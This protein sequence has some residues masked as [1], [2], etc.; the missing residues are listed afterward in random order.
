MSFTK[1]ERMVS[2]PFMSR[3]IMIILSK[4]KQKQNFKIRIRKKG[5]V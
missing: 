5:I 2:V 4:L 3:S 1:Y